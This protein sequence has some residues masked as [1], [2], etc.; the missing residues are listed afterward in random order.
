MQIP[1]PA[2]DLDSQNLFEMNR[3]EGA[4]AIVVMVDT[5]ADIGAA[6]PALKAAL[7]R[8]P[9]KDRPVGTILP[10]RGLLANIKTSPSTKK[11]SRASCL[12]L[13]KTVVVLVGAWSRQSRRVQ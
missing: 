2:T 13:W 12:E 6:V 7:A 11:L 9:N 5:P 3:L 8:Q 4:A 10:A 1:V